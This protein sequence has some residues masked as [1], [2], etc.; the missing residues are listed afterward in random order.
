MSQGALKNQE[1]RITQRKG[2]PANLHVY[3]PQLNISRCQPANLSTRGAFLEYVPEHAYVGRRVQLVF[4]VAEPK[5]VR[6]IRVW[7][8]VVHLSKEGIG[9][10]FTHKY[11]S[12]RVKSRAAGSADKPL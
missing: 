8:I 12:N 1:R 11:R 7:A 10:G 9:F 5:T 3:C 4:S 2:S 6:L